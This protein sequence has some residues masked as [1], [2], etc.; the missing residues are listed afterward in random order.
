M[1]RDTHTRVPFE[2]Q[3]FYH[4]V[5]AVRSLISMLLFAMAN[6]VRSYAKSTMIGILS[7]RTFIVVRDDSALRHS[8]GI[9]QKY[10]AKMKNNMRFRFFWILY[11]I[12]SVVM[13]SWWHMRI[14]C[15]PLSFRGRRAGILVLVAPSTQR[16]S[17]VGS[18][19]SERFCESNEN[20]CM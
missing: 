6:K 7:I 3:G 14:Q 15:S 4:E 5:T 10:V 18:D 2:I 11:V 17:P 16:C 20:C 13:D 8:K 1:T 9:C 19:T 12:F